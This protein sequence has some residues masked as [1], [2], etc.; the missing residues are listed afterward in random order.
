MWRSVYTVDMGR[1]RRQLLVSSL[2]ALL[3]ISFL[4]HAVE[5]SVGPWQGGFGGVMVLVGTWSVVSTY[6]GRLKGP[7]ERG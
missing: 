1:G 6:R 3:G 4:I 5:G 7:P 2:I